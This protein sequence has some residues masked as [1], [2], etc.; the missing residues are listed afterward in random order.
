MLRHLAIASSLANLLYL[1]V[2]GQLLPGAPLHYFMQEPP[3]RGALFTAIAE[4]AVLTLIFWG[5][6]VV[7]RRSRSPW[8]KTAAS[9]L[10]VTAVL[11]AANGFR[12][13]MPQLNLRS[14]MMLTGRPAFLVLAALLGLGAIFVAL[15]WWPR[16]VRATAVVMLIFFPFVP[17]TLVRASWAMVN[18]GE[19]YADFADGPYAPKQPASATAPKPVVMII[20]DELDY[21]IAFENRPPGLELPELDRLAAQSVRTTQAYP[22][23]GETL[24]SIPALVT[25]RRISAAQAIGPRQLQT[26]L[27]DS[28]QIEMLNGAPTMFSAWRAAGGNA[29]AVGFLHPYC[30][31]FNESLVDCAW[32]ADY[33]GQSREHVPGLTMAETATIQAAQVLDAFPLVG[34]LGVRRMLVDRTKAARRGRQGRGVKRFEYLLGESKR[35]LE[36]RAGDLTYLHLPV[37]HWPF[38]F[39]RAQGTYVSQGQRTY[40]DNL[41]LMDRT[42]GELRQIMERSGAWDASTVL[43]TA[44]HWFRFNMWKPWKSRGESAALGRDTDFRVP[45]LVKFPGQTSAQVYEKP[46]NTVLIPDLVAAIGA[47][48]A[49]EVN[50]AAWLDERGSY[51]PPICGRNSAC[52]AQRPP[53][54]A[55]AGGAQKPS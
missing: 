10:F 9:F 50:A 53:K 20:F 25:G 43:I 32:V 38:F 34:R 1:P 41:A 35:I 46:L 29:V 6:A 17:F 23:A 19:S 48:R 8:V 42:L 49:T 45:L 13:Q 55:P 44:D 24:L 14:V 54:A 12:R 39:D 30:R 47:G 11:A 33:A 22:P 7:A 52:G 40:L 15:R 2:W 18:Y 27:A 36:Q 26:T 21:H 5:G 31:V 3:P 51:A 4:V 28:K 16:V 37:P